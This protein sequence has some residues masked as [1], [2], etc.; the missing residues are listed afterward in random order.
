MAAS[1]AHRAR[2]RPVA[3]ALRAHPY[4]ALGAASLAGGVL[5]VA[6]LPL[7][8][9][10][11]AWAWLVWGRELLGGGLDPTNGP[12]WKPLPV[13]FTT[14][15]AL[16][17]EA[18]PI[19]W[20]VVARG[21]AL[22]ALIFAY[23]IGVRL[24]GRLAGAFA[25]LALVLTDLVDYAASADSEP[26][27]TALCLWALERHLDGRRGHALALLALAAL[28]RPETWLLLIPYAGFVW[29]REPR[30]R[31]AAGAVLVVPP[32]LW[33]GPTWL[34]TGDPFSAGERANRLTAASLATA[35]VPALAVVAETVRLVALPVLGAAL[36]AAGAAVAVAL[37]G[38]GSRGAA[39][40][41][42][43]G[44]RA[45]TGFRSPVAHV[46]ALILAVTATL[47]V[48]VVAGLTEVSFTG[49]ERYLFPAVAAICVLGGVGAGV[50]VR[51]VA[52]GRG[53]ARAVAATLV[54]LAIAAPFGVERARDV[55]GVRGEARDRARIIA[56]VEPAVARVGGRVGILACGG[57]AVTRPGTQGTLAWELGLPLSAV[58]RSW[59]P[60]PRLDLRPPTVVFSRAERRFNLV[61]R[62]EILAPRLVPV[63]LGPRLEGWQV[64]VVGA[65]GEAARAAVARCRPPA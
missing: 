41:T 4:L 55:V 18:A 43:V 36:V 25:V 35:D 39:L 56:G 19:L 64:F 52:G 24:S 32:A 28:G 1:P 54:L 47:W 65:G 59:P 31:Y 7:G 46:G 20:T 44:R 40:T 53:G 15:L 60:D 33:L 61:A 16:L 49:N 51:A 21:G 63:P 14:P 50:I 30:L 22:L 42:A 38:R 45:R 8:I 9:G 6:V 62:R 57:P 12:S 10:S 58:E 2:H 5:S 11:D 26:L 27:V 34:A 37:G 23:R 13:V 48:A 3:A 17:G 29:V